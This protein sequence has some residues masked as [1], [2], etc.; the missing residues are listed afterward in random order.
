MATINSIGSSKPVEVVFGGTGAA[1][2]T[3]H[4]I[5][6]GSGTGAITPLGAA[7]NGQLP[8]GS[9]GA[10]PVLA[11]LTAGTGITVTN[12]AGSITIASTVSAL[13]WSEISDATKTIVVQEAYIANRGTQITF[14]LPATAAIGTEFKIQG[15]GAGLWKI[16]QGAGQQIY[17][18]STA[19][20]S[21]AG[22]YLEATDAHDAITLVCITADTVWAT[23]A[24]VGN[25]TVA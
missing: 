5:L 7:S 21:G 20:S 19:T 10:D 3:D 4:G 2:L 8:I 14:T 15:K 12:G 16:A 11:T 22:G 18:G 9:T 25:I 24:V 1:T 23:E 6:L 13:A 17:L